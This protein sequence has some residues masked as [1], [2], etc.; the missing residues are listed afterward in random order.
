MCYRAGLGSRRSMAHMKCA[1]CLQVIAPEDTF[2][3]DGSQVAHLDCR[4]PRD[5]SHEERALLFKYCHEHV[6]ATCPACAR[7][8]R[9]S[10]LGADLLS[11]RSNLC[12]GCRIDLTADL[13]AHLY[14]C[15]TLPT[16]VRRRARAARIVAQML[17]KRT[18]G[19]CDHADV[20]IRE[21][22]AAIA[23]L[24]ATVR[25]VS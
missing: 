24:R 12:P 1:R 4:Q 18:Q 25:R 16:E 10:E 5:L 20:L 11:H 8:L 22:E 7:E 21:A 15:T 6:V 13:R 17:V 14:G 9:Q 3:V 2:A 23:A 19:L